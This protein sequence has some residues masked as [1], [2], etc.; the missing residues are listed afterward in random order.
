MESDTSINSQA[1][2]SGKTQ[3]EFLCVHIHVVLLR[4]RCTRDLYQT[5]AIT[6]VCI[7]IDISSASL[8]LGLLKHGMKSSSH[9]ALHLRDIKFFH[10]LFGTGVNL[11]RIALISRP[12]CWIQDSTGGQRKE[13]TSWND[14]QQGGKKNESCIHYVSVPLILPTRSPSLSRRYVLFPLPGEIHA[15]LFGSSLLS[16]LSGTLDWLSCTLYPIFT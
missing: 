1:Y 15:S 11:P 5:M 4:S 2:F 3:V 14:S 12:W 9:V 8:I 13:E 16:S 7:D 10:G 6:V